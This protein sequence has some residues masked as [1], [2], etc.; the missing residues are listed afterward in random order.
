M[1]ISLLMFLAFIA[2]TLGILCFLVPVAGFTL[3]F[4]FK[5]VVEAMAMAWTARA[6]RCLDVIEGSCT[7]RPSVTIWPAVMRGESEPKGSCNTI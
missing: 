5:P 6:S 1:P 3:R 4:A 2:A 7:N